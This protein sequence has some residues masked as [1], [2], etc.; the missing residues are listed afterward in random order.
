MEE[1]S[2]AKFKVNR[3]GGAKGTFSR[4][5]QFCFGVAIVLKAVAP[6]VYIMVQS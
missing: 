4:W 3:G 1:N 2:K 5:V 6:I